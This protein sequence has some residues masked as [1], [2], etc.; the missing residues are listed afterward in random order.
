[1]ADDNKNILI[2]PATGTTNQPTIRFTGYDVNG[3]DITLRVLDDGSLSIEGQNGQLFSVSDSMSG[4]IYSVNDISGIPS[5][6]VIDDGTVKFAEFGG[7]V[8]IGAAVDDGT[9]K[10]QID[11]SI[12]CGDVSS[13]G[14]V[15]IGGD[16][17]VG[18]NS[19]AAHSTIKVLAGNSYQAG[20]EAYGESQ[21][22]G[23]LYVGQDATDGGGIFYN[24]DG[25]PAFASGEA[26]DRVSFYRKSNNINYLVF[27]YLTTSSAV[28][29]IDS[30]SSTEFIENGTTLSSKYLGIDATA[31]NSQL[32]D[33]IDSSAFMRS[34]SDGQYYG[35]A[36]PGGG[37]TDWVRTTTNG[38]IPVA[39]GGAS[40]LGTAGWPFSTAY[41]NTIY[42]GGTSLT[43]K[44]LGINATA[45][46]A[47][48]LGSYPISSAGNYWGVVAPV[49]TDGVME[50]GK[51]LDFHDTDADASDFSVRLASSG[52]TL[53]LT[54]SLALGDFSI[55]SVQNITL[56]GVI[57]SQDD[58]DTYFQYHAADQC[59]IVTGG[60]ERVEVNTTQFKVSN[61]DIVCTGNITGGYSDER[62]KTIVGDVKSASMGLLH[63][64]CFYFY[65]N[66]LAKTF[67]MTNDERQLGLSA[68]QVLKQYPEVVSLAP[69]DTEIDEQGDIYSKSGDHYLTVDYAKMIVPTIAATN[70]HTLEIIELKRKLIELEAKLDE[71]A[72]RSE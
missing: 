39:S 41:I 15:N 56:D 49:G 64:N 59:R 52:T 50:I 66:E 67:G 30:V 23:Y 51:Y 44:Y 31:A 16:L 55:S 38:I 27:S 4:T 13:S 12:S 37:T 11:G 33:S 36:L 69:I 68:Q 42:E 24:G 26:N 29:F 6:E 7:N 17:V 3:S 32:L 58:A 9:N 20:F 1:M 43:S 63:L 8:L 45:D 57:Y 2:T 53:T 60:L 25:Y 48:T 10:L 72:S 62:F 54:G 35:L 34:T 40:A 46:S 28:E 61:A 5:I 65:E 47:T 71:L 19:K 18:D 70:E 14:D 22:T 21:G